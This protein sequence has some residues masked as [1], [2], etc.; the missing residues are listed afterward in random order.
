MTLSKMKKRSLVL[1]GLLIVVLGALIFRI[2]YWQIVRGNEM[3]EAVLRQQTGE[4]SITASRGTIYDR[5]QKVLAE[6]ATVNTVVC[7]PQQIKKDG[8]ANVVA[9]TLAE[10]LNMDK[11]EIL[12]KLTKDN[13]F[14]YIKKRITV[15]EADAIKKLKDSSVDEEMAKLF[16]GIYFEE[17][18]KRYYQYNIASHII[19]FTGYDNNGIQGIERTFDDYLMGRAGSVLSAQTASGTYSDYQY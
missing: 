5:N 10:V 9:A 1:F 15:E 7:N 14:Q 19:G 18:S 16:S 2:G 12:D 17:D 13:R 8:G 6:S 4:A 3:R 11:D